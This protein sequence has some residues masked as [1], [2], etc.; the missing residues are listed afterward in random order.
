MKIKFF[1]AETAEQREAINLFLLRHHKRQQGSTKGYIAYYAAYTPSPAPLVDSLVAVAKFC[2]LH[3]PAAARF[4]YGGKGGEK[5]VYCLQ[6]LCAYHPPENLLSKFL[7]WCLRE[8]GK[9]ER[10]HFIATYA[11]TDSFRPD[12]RPH[13]GGIYRACNFI[14]C[15]L[16]NPRNK[17]EGYI[18]NG[19]RFSIRKGGKTLKKSDI[20]PEAKII[21]ALPMRRYCIALGSPLTR[22]FRRA[23]LE[24]RM[25]KYQF[26]PVYQPR[27]LI[28]VKELLRGLS[29][30]IVGDSISYW[31]RQ[32]LCGRDL[33]SIGILYHS[34]IKEG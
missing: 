26:K 16:T 20:P 19:E 4:F 3:T 33:D 27:L 5:H 9:D 14:Y 18:L 28:I 31:V 25:A 17:I 6:R 12:G 11:A 1:R 8:M 22:A 23:N 2:P 7:A 29:N 32:R 15:G 24:Q 34:E 21:R 30:N 13:D 10:V